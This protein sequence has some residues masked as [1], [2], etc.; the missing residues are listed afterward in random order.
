[1]RCRALQGPLQV[2]GPALWL[3]RANKACPVYTGANWTEMMRCAADSALSKEQSRQL[4]ATAAR[5]IQNRP[6]ASTEKLQRLETLRLLLRR[7]KIC[8]SDLART[9]LA[10]SAKHGTRFV[11]LRNAEDWSD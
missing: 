9:Q 10:A 2:Q 3:A 11:F 5:G 7:Y 4:S 6:A 8:R 1:V